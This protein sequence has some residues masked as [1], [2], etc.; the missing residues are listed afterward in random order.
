[1]APIWS[2]PLSFR[3]APLYY[4]SFLDFA[5]LRF[6]SSRPPRYRYFQSPIQD[7]V[8][9]W[10]LQ[11][12][13]TIPLGY[14][15][16]ASPSLSGNPIGNPPEVPSRAKA[17]RP[18]SGSAPPIRSQPPFG[19]PRPPPLL[20]SLASGPST[21][22]ISLQ[23]STSPIWS[24]R[25]T[26]RPHRRLLQIVAALRSVRRRLRGPLWSFAPLRSSSCRRL[27]SSSLR[28][29][30]LDVS[31][32]LFLFGYVRETRASL[33]RYLTTFGIAQRYSRVVNAAIATFDLCFRRRCMFRRSRC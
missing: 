29:D 16:I 28:S 17:Y 18:D 32:T 8:L 4:L 19:R 3:R 20:L 23:S 12:F 9:F 5:S 30:S 22:S 33:R 11:I 6:G 10:L 27:R 7:S 21:S 14:T 2:P 13:S 31:T 24:H 1:M 25:A 26:L 15:G